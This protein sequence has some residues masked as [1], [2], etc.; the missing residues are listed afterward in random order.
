MKQITL[1][2]QKKIPVTNKEAILIQNMIE[3]GAKF[4]RTANEMINVNSISIIGEVDTEKYWNGYRLN[5]DGRSFQRDGMRI[6][7]EGR[8]FREIE[9]MPIF[10]EEEEEE[11]EELPEPVTCEI[12]Q[13]IAKKSI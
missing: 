7:L 11:E 2:N 6:Y 13:A 12:G 1:I 9:E 10:D 3:Q 8:N 4:I 5:S